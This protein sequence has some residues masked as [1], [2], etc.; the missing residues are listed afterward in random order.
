MFFGRF[1]KNS[2]ICPVILYVKYDSVKREFVD[3]E[4]GLF[5]VTENSRARRLTFR[6]KNDVIYVTV[7]LGT[8]I[9]E[10]KNAIE[11]LRPK[12]K[13]AQVNQAQTFID[14]NFKIDAD[15][16]KLDLVVGERKRFLSHT[17]AGHTRIICPPDAD[18]NNA[19]LQAWF[20]KVI[21]EALRKNAKAVLPSRLS[22]LAQLH[23]LSYESVSVNSSK[24]RW[25]SCSARKTIN[26]SCYLLLLPSHL[27]D[28]VLLH[29]LSHTREMN[30]GDGFW[31][32]LDDL[33][34]G[35]AK[36]LRNELRQFRINF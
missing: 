3:M 24:G 33:T 30:H 9:G 13:S 17:E 35:N 15:L 5:W 27:I 19:E 2:F 26:L 6:T 29:E 8:S 16:F 23:N 18:F 11:K 20:Y 36:M 4:L 12:L 34:N 1:L 22:T 32:L 28:Y 7:P 10:L 14:L 25:G 31:R 21:L